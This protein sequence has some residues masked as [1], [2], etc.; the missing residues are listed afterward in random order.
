MS[1]IVAFTTIKQGGITDWVHRN[2]SVIFL[3]TAKALVREK[4]PCVVTYLDCEQEY[5]DQL[6][7]IGMNMIKQT[8]SAHLGEVRRKALS[9]VLKMY[10][11]TKYFFWL[12]P[13]KPDMP[14]YATELASVMDK[15]QSILGLFNRMNMDQY[16]PE[17]A[18]YYL[19]CRAAAS[20]LL[21]IDIDYSF[22]PMMFTQTGAKYFLD[23]RGS[24]GDMWDAIL[25]PRLKIIKAKQPFS[26]LP[27]PFM[28]D[29][30]M[31]QLE[32]GKPNFILKRLEQL[33]NIIP[34]LIAELGS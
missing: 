28:N 27:I 12:E 14:H 24:Y 33:N 34:S 2:R 5:V 18:H 13:E 25:I 8:F 30:R 11:S 4:I 21:G 6:T 19:L 26:I 10:P 31:Y 20:E 9:E 29:Q 16:P 1:D 3:D 15:E 22:G 7:N 17:Q 32:V 23:Y